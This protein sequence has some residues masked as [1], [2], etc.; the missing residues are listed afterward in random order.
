MG[1]AV[2]IKVSDLTMTDDPFGS[3]FSSL[4]PSIWV[5]V[6]SRYVIAHAPFVLECFVD[7]FTI[8]VVGKTRRRNEPGLRTIF[9]QSIRVANL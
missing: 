6:F 7:R 4:I 8:L 3:L 2:W 1:I 5:G 9:H